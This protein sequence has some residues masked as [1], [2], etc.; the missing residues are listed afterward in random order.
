MKWTESEIEFLRQNYLARGA[1]W[2]AEQ[3]HKTPSAVHHKAERLRLL[4]PRKQINMRLFKNIK[5][6]MAYFLGLLWADGHLSD[7][8]CELK[9]VET[10]MH[11]IIPLLKRIGDWGIFL[12]K[13]AKSTWKPT[14]SAVSCNLPF[15]TFLSEHGYSTKSFLSPTR[16]L[17]FIPLRFHPYF[18]RGYFDGDGCLFIHKAEKWNHGT[19]SFSGSYEQDWSP[20]DNLMKS[21]GLKHKLSRTRNLKTGHSYSKITLSNKPDLLRFGEFLFGAPA[22]FPSISRKKQAFLAFKNRCLAQTEKGE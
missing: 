4:K 11:E 12:R 19:L 3:L 15:R 2:V 14:V 8:K 18:W 17:N 7:I 9:L 21:M 22:S 6:D 1:K 16:I 5:P 20:L 13:P 10:D